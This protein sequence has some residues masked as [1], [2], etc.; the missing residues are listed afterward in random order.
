MAAVSAMKW[1]P[2][3]TMTSAGLAAASWLRPSESPVIVGDVL[4]FR[5]L[6]IVG[7]DHGPPLCLEPV[8]PGD[9]FLF[10]HETPA[11]LN[12]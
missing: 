9:Y 12:P 5:D 7:Q 4:H 8:D 10:G 2:Q 11:A 6:V 1:T 3:K